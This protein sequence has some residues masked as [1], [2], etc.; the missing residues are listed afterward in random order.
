MLELGHHESLFFTSGWF[1]VSL[2]CFPKNLTSEARLLWSNTSI[3]NKAHTINVRE[4]GPSFPG[5]K[6]FQLG[7]L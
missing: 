6:A 5:Q 7:L 2:Q 4:E 1:D 3:W